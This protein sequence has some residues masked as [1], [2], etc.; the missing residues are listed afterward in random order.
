MSDGQSAGRE[1]GSARRPLRVKLVAAGL[2]L[3]LGFFTLELGLRAIDRWTAVDLFH[4]TANRDPERAASTVLRLGDMIEPAAE[5]ELIYR[6]IPGVRGIFMGA[7]VVI[8]AAGWRGALVP[9]RRADEE[10]RR[11]LIL[12]DSHAFG[13]GVREEARFG[14]RIADRYRREHPGGP[15]LELI[16]LSVPG[17]NTAQELR[18]LEARGWSYEPDAVLLFACGNDAGLAN[19]IRERPSLVSLERSYLI[20][21]LAVRAKAWSRGEDYKN[22]YLRKGLA[23]T[24]K[25]LDRDLMDGVA[26]EDL[27]RIPEAYRGLVGPE[28]VK[29]SLARLAEQARGRGARVVMSFYEEGLEER[30]LERLMAGAAED[31]GF[32]YVSLRPAVSGLLEDQKRE[33]VSL[34]LTPQDPHPTEEYHALIAEALYAAVVRALEGP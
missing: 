5:P 26:A 17:Y 7:P 3:L 22:R 23:K 21:A 28:A 33:L 27:A 6:L 29:R 31:G 30:G 16:N 12:G 15:K 14:E 18:A 32:A 11:L 10:T 25:A 19:F 2:S 13:W 24:R 4:I 1:D 34:F 8:N 9:E 20:D